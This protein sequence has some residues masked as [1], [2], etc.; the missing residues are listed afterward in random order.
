[1]LKQCHEMMEQASALAVSVKDERWSDAERV[2][3]DLQSTLDVVGNS[4]R[5]KVRGELGVPKPDMA[6]RG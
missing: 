4:V 3:A 2:L 5:E 1:M 6:D